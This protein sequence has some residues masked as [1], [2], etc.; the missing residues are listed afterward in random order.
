M[1]L[2]LKNKNSKRPMKKSKKYYYRIISM[3]IWK[4][5]VIDFYTKVT[6]KFTSN[7]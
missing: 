3:P 4:E 7:K 6:L 1:P 5:N 2:E